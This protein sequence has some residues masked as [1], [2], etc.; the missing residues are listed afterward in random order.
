MWKKRFSNV[1]TLVALPVFNEVECVDAVLSSIS[2]YCSDIL[3]VDDGSTD[4]TTEVLGRYSA[5]YSIHHDDNL[6]YG[7]SLIDAFSFA[8]KNDF[9][10]VITMDCD[11]QHEPG[12]LPSFLLEIGKDDADIISGSRY[13]GAKFGLAKCVPAERA[14]INRRITYILNKHLSLRLSDAFCGFKAYRTEAICKLRLS[15]KGYGLGLQVWVQAARVGLRIRE[16]DVPLIYYDGRRNFGGVLEDAKVR[17]AYYIEIIE[18][19]LGYGVIEKTESS[20]DS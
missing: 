16:I 20:F 3:V 1:R 17:F 6:G 5:I 4:G 19:E 7:Q 9:D 13:P 10:W 2:Q 11:H 14:A 15:E 8:E 12:C 18:R